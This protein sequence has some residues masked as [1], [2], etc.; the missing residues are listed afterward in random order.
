MKNQKVTRILYG[1]SV[2]LA[3]YQ[4]IQQNYVESASALGVGLVFDPF[5]PQQT[6]KERPVWKKTW[7]IVHLAIV[8]ALFGLGVG[9]NDK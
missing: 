1:I 2:L 4:I 3:I 9:L 5:D 8:A 6:W 7:L